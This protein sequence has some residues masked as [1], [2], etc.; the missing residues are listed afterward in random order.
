[1]RAAFRSALILLAW[2]AAFPALYAQESD[3]ELG[4]AP[5]IS[6]RELQK[7]LNQSRV[8]LLDVRGSVEYEQGHIPGALSMPLETVEHNGAALRFVQQPIVT[9]CA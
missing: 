7:L 2:A 4:A 3:A 8:L 1:M 6:L 9:Y 5:R